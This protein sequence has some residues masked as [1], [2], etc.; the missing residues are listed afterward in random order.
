MVINIK[1][2]FI[3]TDLDGTLL[4][5][6][7]NIS[8]ENIKAIKKFREDGG[9]FTIATGRGHFMSKPYYN[10][11]NIDVPLVIYN[12]AAIFDYKNDKFIWKCTLPNMAREYIKSVIEKFDDIGIEILLDKD[13]YVVAINDYEQAHLDL[14]KTEHIRCSV[15]DVPDG[16]IKILMVIDENRINELAE[17]L[18][19]NCS[20]GVDY[21]QSSEHYYEMLPKNANKGIAM[22]KLL[23]L[24]GNTNLYSVAIGDFMNDISM[25]TMAN[26]GVA[27]QNAEPQVKECADLIVGSNDENAISQVI[28]FLYKNK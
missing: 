20:E 10:K 17:F 22:L 13:V 18:N 9:K 24:T 14:E 26:L 21:I 4:D 16:W 3:V 2:N 7:K 1:N 5:T 15:D 28:D 23:E 25:I 19:K 12:G 11:L 8:D 27:V 6:E